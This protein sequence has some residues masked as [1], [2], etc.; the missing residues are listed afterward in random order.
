M[1]EV[2]DHEVRERH[3]P[4]LFLDRPRRE[5]MQQVQQV[6]LKE[7]EQGGAQGTAERL[8]RAAKA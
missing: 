5:Q 2:S 3:G 1:G 8:I 4:A 6:L 7:P